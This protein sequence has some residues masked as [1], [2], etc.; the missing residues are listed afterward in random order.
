MYVDFFTTVFDY[1]RQSY[2][3]VYMRVD[4]AIAQKSDD[5]YITLYM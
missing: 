4:A 3:M 1:L 5:M 2:N